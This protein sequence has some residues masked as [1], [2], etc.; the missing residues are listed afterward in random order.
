MSH[1][2]YLKFHGFEELEKRLFEELPPA[3]AKAT[4]RKAFASGSEV[5]RTAAALNA[6]KH[7]DSGMLASSMTARADIKAVTKYAGKK[8]IVVKGEYIMRGVVYPGRIKA[9]VWRARREGG[10]PYEVYANPSKYAH[11][12]ELG[13]YRSAA[14]PFL[15][16]AIESH[17]DRAIRGIA[18]ALEGGLREAASKLA[19]KQ[20]TGAF[21]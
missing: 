13:T 8:R 10:K 18:S 7:S 15:R 17:G 21:K 11:L 20:L 9:K 4:A 16:P 12:V 1:T 19:V 3:L 2:A 14:H 6:A 5:L